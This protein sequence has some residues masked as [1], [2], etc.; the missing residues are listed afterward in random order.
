MLTLK[1]PP[2]LF[3]NG[4]T[5]ESK[6]RFYEADLW[7]WFDGAQ[8][9]IGGWRQ[10]GTVSVTGVARAI[11]TWRDNSNAVWIGIGTHSKLYAMSRSGV[12][13]DITP[14]GFTAGSIPTTEMLG[15]RARAASAAAAVAVLHAITTVRQPRSTS[16]ARQPSVSARTS[17]SGRGPYGARAWSARKS[18]A[19]PGRAALR[20]RHTDKPPRPES[21]TPTIVAVA[22]S[23]MRTAAESRRVVTELA[24]I[25]GVALIASVGL[26]NGPGILNT[27]A[28][29]D[30][31]F[32]LQRTYELALNLRQGVFPA[33][34]MPDSLKSAGPKAVS[35]PLADVPR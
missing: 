20:D 11:T 22:L 26:W 17:A 25:L 34:W 27:R 6:G 5:Y 15:Q 3:K 28:G 16:Q 7:R 14:T 8:R 4:T 31:P 10:K 2:G 18:V 9:P 1:L 32:L 33:R 12:L 30:S 35:R 24:L 21:K 19:R 23:R 29:G 13:T